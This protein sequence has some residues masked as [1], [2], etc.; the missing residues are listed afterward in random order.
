MVSRTKDEV[1]VRNQSA[2][3]G[4]KHN[5]GGTKRRRLN[6][7]EYEWTKRGRRLVGVHKKTGNVEFFVLVVR[8]RKDALVRVS[9]RDFCRYGSIY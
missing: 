7:R 1:P 9:S 2:R 5:V 8:N 4:T 6:A 3:T